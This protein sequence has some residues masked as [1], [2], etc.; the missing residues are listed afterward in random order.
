MLY[1]VSDNIFAE[2][3]KKCGETTVNSLS[4][5]HFGAWPTVRYSVYVLYWGTIV[6]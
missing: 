3:S 2:S 5:G 4:N 1:L 6:V